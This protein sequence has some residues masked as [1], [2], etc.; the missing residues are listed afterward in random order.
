MVN[1]VENPYEEGCAFGFIKTGFCVTLENM[2]RN[3]FDYPAIDKIYIEDGLVCKVKLSKDF[4]VTKEDY[5]LAKKCS[6]EEYQ[7]TYDDIENVLEP[8]LSVLNL[9]E[10]YDNYLFSDSEE[11]EGILNQLTY[12]HFLAYQGIEVLRSE[13]EKINDAFLYLMSD[14]CI[15]GER[16]TKILLKLFLPN[17]WYGHKELY[18]FALATGGE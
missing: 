13:N 1:S 17:G 2:A 4:G 14:D 3:L 11:V 10:S 18:Q 5:D 8:I 9:I 7:G 12:E 16:L 6:S 15:D